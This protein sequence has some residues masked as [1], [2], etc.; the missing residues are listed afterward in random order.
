MPFRVENQY[1]ELKMSDDVSMKNTKKE[2][3]ELIEK[4][5]D[6][7]KNKEKEN[8]NAE[9]T[10]QEVQHKTIVSNSDKIVDAALPM[11]IHQLKVSIN[12]ELT[13]LSDKLEAEAEKYENLKKAIEIKQTELNDLYGVEKESAEL[14][15][16]L[17]AQKRAR[18]EFEHEMRE[19]RAQLEDDLLDKKVGLENEIKLTKDQ[20]EKDKATHQAIQQET[21]NAIEKE[22]KRENEEYEYQLKRKRQLEENKLA[23]Q[24]EKL[25]KELS[26]KKDAFDKQV[27]EKTIELNEREKGVSERE[28][29][30]DEL[31]DK[32]NAFPAELDKSVQSA[33]QEIQERLTKEF[34]QKE[35]LLKKGFEGEI[36]VLTA[37]ISAYEALVKEQIKQIEKLNQQQEKAYEKVQDIANK[38]VSGA[39]ERLQNITVRTTP[40]KQN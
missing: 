25:E 12:K 15:I 38:A 4:L 23:D 24:L 19:K 14:A 21:K 39:A 3:L 2:M 11:Q 33:V 6:E 34:D 40:D 26:L 27:Q 5:K 28:L 10:K 22:R 13:M 36:N 7:I 30:M 31:Q 37:K 29:K 1:G 18:D 17:E 16:I 20:W 9:K 8:L 35:A 32:V